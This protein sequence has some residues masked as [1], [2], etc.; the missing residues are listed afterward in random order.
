MKEDSKVRIILKFGDFN[1]PFISWPSWNIYAENH[2]GRK[3]KS[4]EKKQAEQFKEFC[5]ENFLENYIES[6]TRGKNILD[7]VLTNNH[8]LISFYKTIVN[9]SFSDHV[10]IYI[11]LNFT[12]NKEVAS[13]K[14]KNPYSTRIFEYDTKNATDKEYG[15]FNHVLDQVDEE[16]LLDTDD[17]EEQQTRFYKVLEEAA[18]VCLRKKVDFTNDNYGEEKKK[19]KVYS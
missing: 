19:K 9:K 1:F 4:D 6:P 17:V 5:N 12:F 14:E 18:E 3:V 16:I 13:V 7:L 8:S 10:I 2:E 11:G 15:R